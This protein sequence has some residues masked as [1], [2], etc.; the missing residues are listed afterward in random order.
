MLPCRCIVLILGFLFI[1]PVVS[2]YG[3]AFP[4]LTVGNTGDTASFELVLDQTPEGLSGYNMTIVVTDPQVAEITGVTFPAWAGMKG[5]DILPS[6]SVWIKAADLQDQV[7]VNSTQVPVATITIRGKSTGSTSINGVITQ[8]SDDDGMNMD[9]EVKEGT[10]AVG[11][12]DPDGVILSVNPASATFPVDTT[13]QYQIFADALS[14]GL[15]GYEFTVTLPEDEVG[16]VTSVVYPSWGLLNNTTALPSPHVKLSA[17]DLAQQVEPGA[18]SV[19]LATITV[20][21]TTAGSTPINLDD[22]ELDADGG[23]MLSVSLVQGEAIV[24]SENPSTPPVANFN[25]NVSSGPAPLTVHFT[26][27]STGSP[28]CMGMGFQ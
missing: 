6:S 2:A 12:S 19:L 9:P 23:N 22:V 13:E 1:I 20:K 7:L 18:T 15:A 14:E 28:D 10:F 16:Q 11:S 24:T 8:M 27:T 3:I 4:D 21:G 5:N 26:D 25:K 17:V